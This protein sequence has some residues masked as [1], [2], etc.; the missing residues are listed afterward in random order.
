MRPWHTSKL[1]IWD[2]KQKLGEKM[3]SDQCSRRDI[4]DMRVIDM[5]KDTNDHSSWFPQ[6]NNLVSS[7]N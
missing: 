2:N 7:L 3:R 4:S 6:S 5:L 1:R